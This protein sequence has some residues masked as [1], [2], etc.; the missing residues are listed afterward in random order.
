MKGQGKKEKPGEN[1]LPL[2]QGFAILAIKELKGGHKLL[3]LRA[4]LQKFEWKGDW[5]MNPGSDKHQKWTPEL[6][7]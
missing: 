7:E 1:R 3:R 5:S 6:L 4:P 2:G